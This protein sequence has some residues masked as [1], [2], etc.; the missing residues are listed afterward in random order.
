MNEIKYLLPFKHGV[1][2]G[3]QIS[4]CMIFKIF[5]LLVTPLV[6]LLVYFPFMQSTQILKS[7]MLAV[8]LIFI[9]C[10]HTPL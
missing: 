1:L 7:V 9:M 10:S 6:V 2:N 3:P 4:V 8:S 5:E